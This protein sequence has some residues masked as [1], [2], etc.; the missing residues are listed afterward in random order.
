M[1]HKSITRRRPSLTRE[2]THPSSS[3]HAVQSVAATTANAVDSS[4]RSAATMQNVG[5]M[6]I[7][8][9]SSSLQRP[10]TTKTNT[11]AVRFKAARKT[12]AFFMNGKMVGTTLPSSRKQSLPPNLYPWV[13]EFEIC[14]PLRRYWAFWRELQI[15]KGRQRRKLR[16][17][18]VGD[19][20]LLQIQRLE[21]GQ[22]L[23][24][25]HAG[26]SYVGGSKIQPGKVLQLRRPR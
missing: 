22:L 11:A 2:A 19:S 9:C 23:K 12:S 13:R 24:V 1:I 16:E 21:L 6:D 26:V 8:A 14:K 4:I 3:M 10:R 7:A 18:R 20:R 25:L 15:P 17:T 5:P